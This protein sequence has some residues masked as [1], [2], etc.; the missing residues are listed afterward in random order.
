MQWPKR[1]DYERALH[2]WQAT[3]LDPELRAGQLLVDG[4]GNPIPRD[5]AGLYVC[6]YQVGDWI[7]R[8]FHTNPEANTRPPEDIIERY[9]AISDFCAV[10]QARV[11]ALVPTIYL[12]EGIQVGKNVVPVVK[13]RLLRGYSTLGEFIM[14]HHTQSA[15]MAALADAWM[16]LVTNLENAGI[17]HGDL[18]LT[19]VLVQDGSNPLQLRLVDYDNMFV[20]ALAGRPQNEGGHPPFQNPFIATRPFDVTMDRF[21]ALVIYICLRALAFD[22]TLYGEYQADEGSRLLLDVPDYEDYGLASGNILRLRKRL[23]PAQIDPYFA[24]L[25]ASLKDKT[26]PPRL[27]TIVPAMTRPAASGPAAPAPPL[28]RRST[29]PG[30]APGGSGALPVPATSEPARPVSAPPQQAAPAW[31]GGPA[32]AQRAPQGPPGW[33]GQPTPQP[34]YGLQGQYGKPQPAPKPSFIQEMFSNTGNVLL[35]I[36]ILV[37]VIIILLVAFHL[38]TSGSVFLNDTVWLNNLLHTTSGG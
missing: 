20:P 35:F 3:L 33:Q 12:R 11:S 5:G 14:R 28:V 9:Q 6:V 38:N 8:C 21:S 31:R 37:V 1:K 10:N 18:D 2:T 29:N 32:Q 22:P 19:N 16:A 34:Q 25:I 13:M 27:D 7:V 36:A 17:A 4:A 30:A 23:T 24:A 15:V 26:L